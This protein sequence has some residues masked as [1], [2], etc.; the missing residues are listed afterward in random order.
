MGRLPHSYERHATSSSQQNQ[1]LIPNP[2]HWARHVAVLGLCRDRDQTV[3]ALNRS[4]LLG[5]EPK[6]KVRLYWERYPIV[7]APNRRFVL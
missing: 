7:K 2:A 4:Y 5:Q 1:F 3:E 6:S